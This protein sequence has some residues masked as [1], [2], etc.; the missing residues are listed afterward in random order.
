MPYQKTIEK[1]YKIKHNT[2]DIKVAMENEL[3]FGCEFVWINEDCEED[4][5][6]IINVYGIDDIASGNNGFEIQATKG[7]D[8]SKKIY[9]FDGYYDDYEMSF[10][11]MV[12]KILGTPILLDDVLRAIEVKNTNI[13]ISTYGRKMLI[14][15][16]ADDGYYD[17]CYWHLGLSFTEQPTETKDFIKDL[18]K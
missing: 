17:K 4:V 6:K 18:L 13:Q 2:D 14:G 11:Q 10:V 1:I 7:E 8:V 12:K 9:S 16:Y 15:K 5:Y 3:V